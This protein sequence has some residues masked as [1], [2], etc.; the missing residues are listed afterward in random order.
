MDQDTESLADDDAQTGERNRGSEVLEKQM[1]VGRVE[2][3]GECGV[4][5]GD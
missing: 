3:H 1:E 2:R 4:R 5:I